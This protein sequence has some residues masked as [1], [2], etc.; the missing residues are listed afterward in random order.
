MGTIKGC[1]T[2]TCIA[3]RKKVAYKK[4]DEYCSKCGNSLYAVCKKCH[5]QLQ[6]DSEKYR[7]RCV[8]ERQ[9][10]KDNAQKMAG[11]IGKAIATV[12]IPM[13][14]DVGRKTIPKKLK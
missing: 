10:R 2:E 9:D 5:M 14:A 11:N 12:V 13:V 4:T 6:D 7:V 3:N 8:V 1:V